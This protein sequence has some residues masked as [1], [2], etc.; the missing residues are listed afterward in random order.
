MPKPKFEMKT[1]K[2]MTLADA[3][4]VPERLNG[5]EIKVNPSEHLG[6]TIREQTVTSI[7]Q[8]VSDVPKAIPITVIPNMREVRTTQV[9]ISQ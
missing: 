7:Q 2:I 3:S 5:I 8:T 4:K 6:A 9:R 1:S